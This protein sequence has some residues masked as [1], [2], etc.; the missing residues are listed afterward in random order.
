[1]LAFLLL[2]IGCLQLAGG[3]LLALGDLGLGNDEIF[4]RV[5]VELAAPHD[6]VCPVEDLVHV[7]FGE[8]LDSCVVVGYV[9]GHDQFGEPVVLVEFVHDLVD[10]VL[11]DLDL[12]QFVHTL[13]EDDCS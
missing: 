3:F 9:E 10:E 5:L 7:L 11:L 12:A 2:V 13:E 1:M 8:A 4:L 6:V